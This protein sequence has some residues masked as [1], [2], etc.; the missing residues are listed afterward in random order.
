MPRLLH[1]RD[2]E[3]LL[4]C[5]VKS[6]STAAL[7]RSSLPSDQQEDVDVPS[8]SVLGKTSLMATCE[9]SE[10]SRQREEQADQWD[11]LERTSMPRYS[12]L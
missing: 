1:E 8:Y 2:L 10:R 4:D 9:A 7:T 3:V 11:E 5:G 12:P 6:I